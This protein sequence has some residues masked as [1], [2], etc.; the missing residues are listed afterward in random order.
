MKVLGVVCSPRKGGNTEILVSEA[1]AGARSSGAETELWT[2]VGKRLEPCDACDTCINNK[3]GECH[4]QDDMQEFYPKVI[5]ADGIIFGSPSFFGSMTAQAKTVIDRLYCLYNAYVLPGK[6]AGVISVATSRGHE[7]VWS[8]FANFFMHGH[9]FFADHCTG[10]A[11][12]KGDVLKDRHAM[13][14]SAELGRQV[15]ALI[16]QGLRYPEEFKKPL[17]RLCRDKYGVDS[18]PLNRFET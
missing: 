17:Y 10:F 16:K 18:F 13:K 14:T 6:V 15:V 8:Q 1:L 5:A 12:D 11:R 7:P 3:V 9:M 2:V 4:I